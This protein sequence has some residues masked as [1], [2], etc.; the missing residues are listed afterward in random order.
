MS[1]W[2]HEAFLMYKVYKFGLLNISADDSDDA[3][4]GCFRD[5]PAAVVT[6]FQLHMAN[7]KKSW[8]VAMDECNLFDWVSAAPLSQRAWVFQE[9]QLARRALHFTKHEVFWECS[10]ADPCCACE[11]YSAGSSFWKRFLKLKYE[12]STLMNGHDRDSKLRVWFS[13]CEDF[14]AKA[15]TFER[16]VAGASGL[17]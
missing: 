9:R 6:P 5:R 13:M 17:S 1:D 16:E 11:T 7:L 10:A 2:V 4:A 3:R 12:P 15:L 14:S 8:W